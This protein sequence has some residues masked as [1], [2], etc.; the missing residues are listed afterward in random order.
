VIERD[1]KEINDLHNS[2]R[3]ADRGLFP[4]TVKEFSDEES[5]IFL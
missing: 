5:F 4:E 3:I 1:R 2:L